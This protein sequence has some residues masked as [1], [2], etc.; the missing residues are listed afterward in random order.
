MTLLY[1]DSFDHYDTS[2][3]GAKWY[4]IGSTPDLS[5]SSGT[6]RRGTDALRIAG[7][8]V[9]SYPYVDLYYTSTPNDT[10]FVGFALKFTSWA[11]SGQT[12]RHAIF[13][14]FSSSGSTHEL[15]MYRG[16]PSGKLEIR[17]GHYAVSTLLDTGITELTTNQWYWI[18]MKYYAHDSSGT[19][20]VYLNGSSEISFSGDTVY[21]SADITRVGF[22]H[23]SYSETTYIDDFYICDDAG[24]APTNTYLGDVK[25]ESLFADGAGNSTDMTPS[26]G[27][28]YQCVDENPPNDDTDYVY[29]ATTGDHDTYSFG[30]LT[31]ASGTIYGVQ[32]LVYARKADAG[33]RTIKSVVRSGST[34]Y[35][36]STNHILSD[37]YLYHI[38][39]LEDDPDTASAWTISG[40]NAAEF[41]VKLE[42]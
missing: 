22:G 11:S 18:E 32:Q 5:I 31:A 9:E 23:E 33:S 30:N 38:D 29:E 7:N 10:W 34:D 3:R 28:N 4:D 8:G 25:V 2:H 37:S 26:T 15:Y 13:P 27:S 1:V 41:G 19:V 6:G 42:A 35:P 16:Y 36:N 39:V 20:D 21:S 12:S 40:V 14:M 24:S 17:R